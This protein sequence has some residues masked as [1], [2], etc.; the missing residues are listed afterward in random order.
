[1]RASCSR[2]LFN[3]RLTHALAVCAIGLFFTGDAPAKEPEGN[4][5]AARFLRL[6]AGASALQ[7]WTGVVKGVVQ[8]RTTFSDFNGALIFLLGDVVTTWLAAAVFVV[9]EEG[10]AR[11]KEA[12][13]KIAARTI[14]LSPSGA[15][16]LYL[17]EREERFAA[18]GGGDE[19][20]AG[21]KAAK[22]AA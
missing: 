21:H 5:E 20:P 13:G 4:L 19:K 8:T 14:V 7:F 3:V 6:A 11:C 17:A 12:F 16:A 15:F 10:P 22:K 2:S 9:V 1:M 18:N